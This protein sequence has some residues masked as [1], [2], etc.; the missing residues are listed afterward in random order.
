MI[1]PRHQQ[2][3]EHG[4]RD[5]Q[6]ELLEVLA[7]DAA[8]EAHRHEHG[9][10]GQRDGDD[11]QA[12]LVGGL[13]RRAIGA[14]A[15]AHVAHDVLDLDDRVVDQDAGDDGDGEQ[16]DEVER[17]A[18]RIERPERRND[19][20]RQRDGRD[21][22]R[23]PVAQEDEHHDDGE[24]GALDQRLH[25][26]VIGAE[27]VGHH[28]VDQLELDVGVRLLQLRDLLGDVG[29]DHRVARAL[30]ARD[31][32]G[33]HRRA[34]ERGERARLGGGVRDACRAGRGAPCG[35][36]GSVIMVAARSSTVCL[37]ASVRIACSR[38]PIS[39]RPPARST[40]RRPQLPVHVAGGD[41][42][43]EQ[44]V[45]IERDADLAVDAADAL[46][47][48][49]ALH[50]LQRAHDRVVDEPGQLLGRHARRARRIGH[51]RQALDLDARDD[52]LFDGA[53]QL[54]ADAR[55]G[56]LHVV[57]RAV[58]VDLQPELDG[59]DRRAFGDRRGLVLDAVDAGDGILDLLGDLHLEL[60]RRRARLVDAHLHDRH[61]DVGKARDRQL[62][63]A[64]VAERHQHHEQHQRRHRLADRPGRDVPVHQ[65][66]SLSLVALGHHRPHGVAVAQ[67]RA[68][69]R[70]PRGRPRPG[71][72]APRPA[73]RQPGP[74]LILRV[75][76]RLS[77]TTC[78]VGPSGP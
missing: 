32:E 5:H 55:D 51:D 4:E 23:A 49:H 75:S 22:R 62:A 41:A 18:R 46:D 8:H 15:H 21:Q 40:L 30:G 59:R 52:R 61:V 14:L 3:E 54:G 73:R 47:L 37:P 24:D 26:R 25:G 36:R 13:Q 10:D 57:E 43:G 12:D 34:V 68:G 53:R 38:P 9:D 33:D 16:A 11:G 7:G 78:T 31:G 1:E 20:Q 65:R 69:A 2:R 35:P 6:A 67:E 60:G 45:G 56:I 28:R 50:A 17:E 44:P 27:R 71:P 77:R 66:A 19:R 72:R 64:H 70:R 29:G 39:P 74:V 63:E 48:R 42:E 58:L 76:T